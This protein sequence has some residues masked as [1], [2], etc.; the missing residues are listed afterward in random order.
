MR[1]IWLVLTAAVLWGVGSL[2]SKVAVATVDPWTA[3]LVRSLVFFPIVAAF[4]LRRTRVS[5]RADRA[6][7]YGIGAGLATGVSIL[8]ARVAL[9]AYD[10][11][12]VSPVRRLSLLVTVAVAVLVFEE[13]LT[14][15]KLAGVGAAL[16]GALLLSV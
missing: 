5:W 9:T 3:A 14:A 4:V 1:G 2:F 11:S 8:S 15:R 13:S 10:V 12:L 7:L 6:T 16:G